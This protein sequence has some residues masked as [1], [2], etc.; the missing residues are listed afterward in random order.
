MLPRKHQAYAGFTFTELLI[1]MAISSVVLG[2]I[3]HTFTTQRR[4]YDIQE[5]ISAMLQNARGA[6]E[7]I[8]RE[9]RMAGYN[10]TGAAFNGVTYNASQLQLQADLN[11]DGDTANTDETI[12]YS[13]DAI[14]LQ[15]TRAANGTTA[16]LADYI[17]AMTLGYFDSDGNATTVSA[18]IRQVQVSITA[19]T[20]EP[21]PH[22]GDNNGYRTYTLT[23]LLTPR[24]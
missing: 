8:A 4:S 15:I 14:T 17:T 24:N 21:D 9:A 20:A 18:D 10:P 11:G 13:H 3:V 7:S 2:A 5:Q 19:R 23:S 22:Y 16:P 1:A 12:T 6:M